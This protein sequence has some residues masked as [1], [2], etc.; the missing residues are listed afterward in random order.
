MSPTRRAAT[1]ASGDEPH[2][3]GIELARSRASA[4]AGLTNESAP[5]RQRSASSSSRA[6]VSAKSASAMRTR[7]SARAASSTGTVSAHRLARAGARRGTGTNGARARS[8]SACSSESGGPIATSRAPRRPAASAAASASGLRPE[9]E[10]AI[11]AS[12]APT[13]PGMPA[14]RC[15]TTGTGQ[16]G[17]ATV[18]SRSPVRAAV[19]TPA[20]TTARGRPSSAREVRLASAAS[21]ADSRTCAPAEAS[22]RSI[23]RRVGRDAARL[24]VVEQRLLD[25]AVP[26]HPA[27]AVQRRSSAPPWRGAP[28]RASS[29]SSTGMPSR[30]SK[31]RPHSVQVR[32]CAASS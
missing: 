10:T 1:V 5:G 32:V 23:P 6:A 30:I 8:A 11:T 7:P 9:A 28:R 26:A 17:P 4:L 14:L 22:A 31:I 29:S 24:G 12:A 25:V 21:A 13:Q 19:P 3:I 27:G 2:T 18:S 16:R 15:P 20:T